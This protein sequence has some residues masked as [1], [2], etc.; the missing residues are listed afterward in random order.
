MTVV[1]FILISALL[2]LLPLFL[3]SR[4][5]NHFGNILALLHHYCHPSYF[6]T[7]I[8]TLLK[9]EESK[10]Q[11]KSI[12]PLRL[13]LGIGLYACGRFQEAMKTLEGI[14]F[15]YHYKNAGFI[16]RYFH[17]KFLI[18]LEI[19]RQDVAWGSL[20]NMRQ[21]LAN[22][23]KRKALRIFS[24]IY[25]EDMH[26]LNVV[27]NQCEGA[28]EVLQGMLARSQSNYER[29]FASYQLGELYRQLGKEAEAKDAYMDVLAYGNKL[30]IAGKS[31][32][33][34]GLNGWEA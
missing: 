13:Y 24:T 32:E 31:A 11:S 33:R 7:K 10:A 22:I 5:K 14:E 28:E 23:R 26:I 1:I 8:H 12:V 29:S 18:A 30:Y 16:A 3:A 15:C 21:A 17:F 34:L 19:E 2:T 4:R 27:R 6:V 20:V 25:N 9:A